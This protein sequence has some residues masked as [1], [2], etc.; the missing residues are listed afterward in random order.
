MTKRDDFLYVVQTIYLAECMRIRTKDEPTNREITYLSPEFILGRMN[1]IF[2][3]ADR[4]PNE[5]S[6]AEAAH[7]FCFYM[8]DTLRENQEE[9]TGKEMTLPAWFARG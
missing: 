8:I 2:Y 5:L 7:A 3:A 6:A 1:E 4:I 9:A